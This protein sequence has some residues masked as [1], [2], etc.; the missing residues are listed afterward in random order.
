MYPKKIGT[1]SHGDK[2]PP[3]LFTPIGNGVAMHLPD[4]RETE[5]GIALPDGVAGSLTPVGIVVAVGP[6]CVQVKAGDRVVIFPSHRV[7]DLT[8]VGGYRYV[9][10]PEDKLCAVLDPEPAPAA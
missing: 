9:V 2:V 3:K 10:V 6:K 8:L 7:D 5:S 4:P 1:L